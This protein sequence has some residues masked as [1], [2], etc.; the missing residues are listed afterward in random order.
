MTAAL[1]IFSPL[2]W[3]YATHGDTYAVSGFFAALVGYLCW[4]MLTDDRAAV[5]P[6]ALALGVASGFR[7]TDM[8]FLLPL[9]LWSVRRRHWTRIVLGPDGRLILT[10][11][12]PS[13]N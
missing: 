13:G 1:T 3:V 7:P 6:A 9:W 5:W 12:P 8:L 11:A 10:P 4:R 2:A